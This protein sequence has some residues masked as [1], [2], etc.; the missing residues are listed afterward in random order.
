MVLQS[1]IMSVFKQGSERGRLLREGLK[2]GTTLRF[3]PGRISRRLAEANGLDRL[4]NEPRIAVRKPRLALVS[5]FFKIF[6]FPFL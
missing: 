6:L 2:F 5:V 4:R 3:V 1:S